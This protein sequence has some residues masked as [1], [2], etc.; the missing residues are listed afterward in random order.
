MPPGTKA[1]ELKPIRLPDFKIKEAYVTTHFEPYA[2][3]TFN[4]C[5][6][7]TVCQKSV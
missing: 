6:L 5:R 3:G 1:L 4:N 2:T 7:Q